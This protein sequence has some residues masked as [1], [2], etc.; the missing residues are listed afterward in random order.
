MKLE[1]SLKNKFLYTKNKNIFKYLYFYYYKFIHKFDV[2]KSYSFNGIDLLIDYLFKSQKD[3]VYIDIGCFHP[4]K[5]NNTFKLFQK[6]WEGINVDIDFHSIEMFDF[7]RPNDFNKQIAIS[8]KNGES[9]LFFYHNKSKINTLS[10]V[11]SESREAKPKEIKKIKTNTLNSVIEI[12]PFKN[13][14]INFLNIDVEG[15]EMNVL[16]G[17]DIK[18]YH[19]D[20]VVIEYLDI[21]MKKLEFHNQNIAGIMDSEIYKLMKSQNYHFVN[22]IHS[23]LVFVSSNI[24]N[25]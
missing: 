2:N 18:K 8:D 13:K 17:F 6:G 4:I 19:P 3:G 14:K 12:S 5:G 15:Y 16:K 23:D 24:R 10:R 21:R 25:I 7:F 9:D 1:E 22:W 20:V 11:V